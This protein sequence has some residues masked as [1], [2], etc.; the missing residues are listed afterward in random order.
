MQLETAAPLARVG[1]AQL[2]TAGLPHAAHA[3]VPHAALEVPHASHAE[4]PHASHAEVPHEALGV[5]PSCHRVLRDL[6]AGEGLGGALGVQ[7]GGPLVREA[8]DLVACPWAWV[9]QTCQ[10]VAC[11]RAG[12]ALPGRVPSGAACVGTHHTALVPCPCLPCQTVAVACHPCHTVQEVP[13]DCRLHAPSSVAEAGHVGRHGA[14]LQR[15]P[16]PPPRPPHHRMRLLHLA[17]GPLARRPCQRSQSLLLHVLGW[18][19]EPWL[20][21]SCEPDSCVCTG[22]ARC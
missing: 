14:A 21:L 8:W 10:G 4:A 1:P 20:G 2:E 11:H 22:L 9:H 18:I 5:P 19:W 3:E 12:A 7:G 6:Q 13:F 17:S 15:A 16:P